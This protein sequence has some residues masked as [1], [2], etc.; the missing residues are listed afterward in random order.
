MLSNVILYYFIYSIVHLSPCRKRKTKTYGK[1]PY[2]S[3][4]GKFILPL[5]EGVILLEDRPWL[6]GYDNA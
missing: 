2:N 6:L 4:I 5:V 3:T 1:D